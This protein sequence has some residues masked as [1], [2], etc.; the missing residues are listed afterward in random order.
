MRARWNW[1]SGLT[2]VVSG[3][4]EELSI[5]HLAVCIGISFLKEIIAK[6]MANGHAEEGKGIVKDPFEATVADDE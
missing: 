4:L 5:A 6:A 3:H 1:L 2:E